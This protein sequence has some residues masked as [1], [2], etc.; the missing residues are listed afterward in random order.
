MREGREVRGSWA[1]I[2]LGIGARNQDCRN[3]EHRS[4]NKTQVGGVFKGYGEL[5]GFR[6]TASGSASGAKRLRTSAQS[7]PFASNAVRQRTRVFSMDD[8]R[9]GKTWA[10]APVI[11]R[12]YRLLRILGRR[13]ALRG[14]A[15]HAMKAKTSPEYISAV[16]GSSFAWNFPLAIMAV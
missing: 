5:P 4:A 8:F 11:Q 10:E 1:R 2:P 13:S 16:R 7:L 3:V 14:G 15:P 9:S 12:S 6:R